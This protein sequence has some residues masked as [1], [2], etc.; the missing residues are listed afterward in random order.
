MSELKELTRNLSWL[1]KK[2][3]PTHKS[4]SPYKGSMIHTDSSVQIDL[5]TPDNVW[6]AEK[7]ELD[8][9]SFCISNRVF[10][11]FEGSIEQPSHWSLDQE[12]L[13]RFAS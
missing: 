9:I 5:Q 4:L 1:K 13:N 6:P 7:N 3:D 2:S 11:E 8:Y 10:T 12:N